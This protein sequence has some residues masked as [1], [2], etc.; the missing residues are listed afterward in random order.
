MVVNG[1]HD[2]VA[3]VVH[4]LMPTR[5]Q[6]VEY[7]ITR[8]GLQVVGYRDL[9]YD[10]ALPRL[11]TEWYMRLLLLYGLLIDAGRQMT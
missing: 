1:I 8:A 11:P 3:G 5:N 7:F 6:R 2:T 4:V 9:P 10:K